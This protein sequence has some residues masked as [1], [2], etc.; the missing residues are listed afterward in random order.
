MEI[1]TILIIIFSVLI[2]L[3]NCAV[4]FILFQ[5]SSKR[6]TENEIIQKEIKNITTAMIGLSVIQSQNEK[7]LNSLDSNFRKSEQLSEEQLNMIQDSFRKQSFNMEEI[8]DRVEYLSTEVKI[9]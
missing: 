2:I 4:L 3:I 7:I 9:D 1:N 6:R 8:K 5:S